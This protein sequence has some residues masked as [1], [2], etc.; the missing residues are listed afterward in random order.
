M[1]VKFPQHLSNVGTKQLQFIEN[2]HRSLWQVVSMVPVSQSLGEL[3]GARTPGAA[4]SRPG[5]SGN[6]DDRPRLLGKFGGVTGTET[7][8]RVSQGRK[9]APVQKHL[10]D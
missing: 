3:A 10:G 8:F 2:A 5:L 4:Q 7:L 6:G 9:E 1:G